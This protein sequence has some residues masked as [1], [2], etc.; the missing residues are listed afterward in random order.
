M[1]KEDYLKLDSD[2][3]YNFLSSELAAGKDFNQILVSIGMTKEDLAKQGFYNV[4]GKI[5]RK[6]IKGYGTP[7]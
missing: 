6:P 4:K 7:K 1:N 2:S 3:K 5:M